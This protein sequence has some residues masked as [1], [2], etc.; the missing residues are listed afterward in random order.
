MKEKESEKLQTVRSQFESWRAERS[1]V[2]L[3]FPQSLRS[4]ATQLL[5]DYPINIV[6]EELAISAEQLRN[7]QGTNGSKANVK[8]VSVSP[9]EPFLELKAS[10]LSAVK[11]TPN[12]A[13]AASRAECRIVIERVDGSRLS[14]N[15]PADWEQLEAFCTNFL[16]A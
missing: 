3:P 6:C 5:K 1:R 16:R 2:S 8:K 14:V 12:I 9:S 11:T 15:L 10:Q 4:A 13:A 7:W